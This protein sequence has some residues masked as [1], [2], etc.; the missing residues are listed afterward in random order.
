MFW[1]NFSFL[2]EKNGK[3]PNTVATE[4]K[5]SSGSVTAWKQ[6]RVPKWGTLQKIADY[7]SVSVENLISEKEKPTPKGEPGEDMVVVHR[8]GERIVYHI[9]EDKLQAIQPLL[10]SLETKSDPDL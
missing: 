3:K 5:I 1:E 2:C 6:G 7:F 8:N 10:E 4:L 9:T